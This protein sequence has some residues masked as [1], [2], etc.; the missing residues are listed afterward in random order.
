MTR[1]WPAPKTKVVL[2]QP[3]LHAFV[4]AVS[5]YPHLMGGAKADAL[6]SFGLSQVTTP[7]FT[8]PAI[9]DWLLN[10][11]NNTGRPLGSLE[12]LLSPSGPIAT[13]RGLVMA[14]PATMANIRKA[15]NS[16]KKRC[17]SHQDNTALFYFC[18]HGMAKTSQYL[19]AQDFGDPNEGDIG[20]NCV[21]F[22]AFR[23]GM[24]S[25]KARTQLF[26]VDACRETPFNILSLLNLSGRPLATATASDPPVPSSSAYFATTEGRPAYGPDN[27]PT[28]F[29][30]AL[31][32]CLNGVA[33]LKKN[34]KFVVD[35]FSLSGALGQAMAML[36]QRNGLDLTANP[37][38]GGLATIH[39]APAHRV[40]FSIQCRTKERR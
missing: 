21:D 18:G 4:I 33:T 34:G 28:Y 5:D 31:L 40:I 15:F 38:P 37:S 32:S 19:L 8:G 35:T 7:R 14:A 23:V 6:D 3:R 1:I 20:E 29:C 27:G 2:N 16:W 26:F 25:C 24:R 36:G 39:E 9:A 10:K 13:D 12:V 22:D 30:Q 11:L 17:N